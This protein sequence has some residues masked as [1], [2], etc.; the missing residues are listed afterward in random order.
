MSTNNAS[1]KI[2]SSG[3]TTTA[4]AN[5]SGAKGAPKMSTGGGKALEAARKPASPMDPQQKKPA[6]PSAWQR[7]STNPLTNR[8]SGPVVSNGV[9]NNAAKPASLGKGPAVPP[10]DSNS[11]DKQSSDRIALL[12]AHSAGLNAIITLKSGERYTGTFSSNSSSSRYQIKMAKKLAPAGK[13]TNGA[14]EDFVGKGQ[15]RD[16]DFDVANVVDLALQNVRFE[17]PKA[18]NGVSSSFMTDTDISAGRGVRERNLERWDSDSHTSGIDMSL[19]SSGNA[20]WDQFEV[21]KKITGLESTYDENIYTTVI[22]TNAPDY[23]QRLAKAT[24]VEREIMGSGTQ[25]NRHIAE[26]RGLQMPEDNGVDEESKYSGVH[27][28]AEW[29]ALSSGQPNKYTPPAARKAAPAGV[30]SDP[31]ILS[32]SRPEPP[33]TAKT[34]EPEAGAVKVPAEAKGTKVPET[35]APTDDKLTDD[36]AAPLKAAPASVLTPQYPRG[37]TKEGGATET[38]EKDVVHAFKQFT[39]AEKIRVQEHQRATARR[40]KAVK[41]N[42]LKK[43]AENFKLHTAVPKDLVPILAKDKKKQDEIVMK[44]KIAADEGSTK[45]TPTKVITSTAATPITEQKVAK[46]AATRAIEPG[47][48]SPLASSDRHNPR[49][50]N[51]QAQL[52]QS[53]RGPS[54]GNQQLPGRPGPGNLGNRLAF[55]QQ[56]QQHHNRQ[57]GPPMNNPQP[58]YDPRIPPTGPSANSSGLTSPTGSNKPWNVKANAFTPNPNS[59]TF[60]PTPSNAS[61]GSSPVRG[62]PVSRPTELRAPKPGNF[63]QGRAPI[64]PAAERPCVGEAFNPIVR[65]KKEAEEKGE[66]DKFADNGGIPQAFRTPPTWPTNKENTDVTYAMLF[67]QNQQSATSVPHHNT[68]ISQQPYQNQLPQFPPNHQGSM[69]MGHTPHQTPRHHNVQPHHGNPGTPHHYDDNRMQYSHST[70]SVQPSP[71]MPPNYLQPY[72]V[73]GQP[74]QFYPQPVQGFA[75]QGGGQ[76]MAHRQV[77]N[78]G[79]PQFVPQ[80]MVGQMGGPMMGHAP[81]GPQFVGVPQYAYP[82]PMPNQAYPQFANGMPGQPGSS[83]SSPR[84]PQMIPGPQQGHPPPGAQIMYVQQHPGQQPGMYPSP[85]QMPTVRG[86]F[87]GQL[88][89]QYSAS[90]HYP[91]P[92]QPHRGTAS[93]SYV[94]PLMMQAGP[95]QGMPPSGPPMAPEGASN[96][97]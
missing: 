17:K 41:L 11:P 63:F 84:A 37:Q 61:T 80:L 40:D 25:G 1:S 23:K 19:S 96:E 74:G 24:K 55:Q 88:Q 35:K 33:T 67:E 70:S 89:Q 83:Y 81:G 16:M 73:Q 86:P 21:N 95:P 47:H 31:S 29:K 69:H 18:Q 57:S 38:V 66:K 50:R 5:A 76:P 62:E 34:P 12:L 59:L 39:Q 32:T 15:D 64:K 8:A 49:S 82:S 87:P 30:S 22:N 13:Q 91:Q 94:Q 52:S 93:G 58:F 56:Q 6:T 79:G 72:Q 10:K 3:N 53:L 42:D 9:M 54:A 92:P 45:T 60:V 48:T 36:K 14:A 75:M 28:S 43:F 90:P 2:T 71:R 44:A 7:G 68:N 85:G 78:G 97:T 51:N 4:S 26:E 20:A 46:S 27:R 65:M 77:S